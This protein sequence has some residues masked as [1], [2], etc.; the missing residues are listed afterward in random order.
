[1][2][3]KIYAFLALFCFVVSFSSCMKDDTTTIDEAW[4]SYNDQQIRDVIANQYE[5]LESYSKNGF[6]YWKN[7]DFIANNESPSKS[8]KITQDRKPYFTDSVVVRYEGW[9]LNYD[10]SKYVFGTT[11][12]DANSQ[13]GKGCRID[14]KSGLKVSELIEYAVSDGL[15]TILQNMTIGQQVEVVIPYQL[16][17]GVSKYLNIPAYSTIRY[18]IKLLKIIPNNSTEFN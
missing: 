15:A 12:G 14:S 13:A 6:V 17:Y 7:T 10:G 3:K 16:G 11:E 4:K 5:P 9:Y 2:N 1:M 18:K 8:T